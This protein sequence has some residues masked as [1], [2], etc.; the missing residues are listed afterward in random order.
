MLG[1]LIIPGGTWLKTD[2]AE[3]DLYIEVNNDGEALAKAIA[4]AERLWDVS[5][6][7]ELYGGTD[8]GG[9]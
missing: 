3:E 1:W 2:V 6:C 8:G 5:R 9:A 7:Y 4:E